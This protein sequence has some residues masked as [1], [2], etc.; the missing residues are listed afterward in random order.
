VQETSEPGAYFWWPDAVLAR[1]FEQVRLIRRDEMP[2]KS[3]NRNIL[4]VGSVPLAN[5]R[6]VFDE[7]AA[8]L[9]ELIPRM[10][11]GETGVRTMWILCQ[12]DVMAK[13][14]NLKVHH[15]FDIA[16]GLA[17]TV[18]E[19]A[20]P[21]KPVEFA[22]LNYAAAAKE[23]Y[24]QFAELKKAGKI[25]ATTKFQVSL[26]TAVAVISGFIV[27]DSQ[28]LVEKPY[29]QALKKELE[30]IGQSIP[31][32]DL[33]I[34]WDVAH[35]VLFLEGWQL[36]TFV[37]RSK[38]GLLKRIVDLGSAVPSDIDLGFHLCY[39]DPGHKHLVEPSDLAL[40]VELA[41]AI[42]ERSGRPVQWIHMPVPRGRKDDA[43]FAPLKDLRLPPT[44][45]L[46]LGLIHLTDGVAGA[47]SRVETAKRYRP[48]FGVAC[49]CGFGRRS[50]DTVLPL[51]D[52]HREVATL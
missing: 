37:D 20:D 48:E 32:Q 21:S 31:H 16:P 40:S 2:A 36:E 6:Q 33:A 50:P 19:V 4:L 5:A 12:K 24:R 51:L 35:E 15:Q 3:Q 23:S 18:Y 22:T 11:D 34:Q 27:P 17:Q 7:C 46:Y 26:P 41:N 30:E 52:L 45:E 25:T 39:G 14:K 10:P 8:R 13:A 28:A 44:T 43:Y 9:G 47:R 49:E 42:V 1:P 29:T 38:D